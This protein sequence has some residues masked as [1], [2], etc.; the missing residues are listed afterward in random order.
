M[1]YLFWAGLPRVVNISEQIRM[2]LDAFDA[3]RTVSAAGSY[4]VSW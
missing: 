4:G 3:E 1:I 2:L